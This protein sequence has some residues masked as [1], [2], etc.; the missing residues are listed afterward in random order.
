MTVQ[1]L[2]GAE[3]VTAWLI[4]SVKMW[5]IASTTLGNAMIELPL[6]VGLAGKAAASGE[7][8]YTTVT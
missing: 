1:E 7:D 3:R 8:R 5:N 2:V 6:G 4:D